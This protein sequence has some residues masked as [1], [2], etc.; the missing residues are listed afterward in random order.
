MN[1]ILLGLLI[2]M[3]LADDVK[4]QPTVAELQEKLAKTEAKLARYQNAWFACQDVMAD[5]Q[6][7]AQA[8]Q[9]AKPKESA[10]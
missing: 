3:L 10:K 7:D 2:P 4:P 9:Q 1:K 5:A 8:K 6:I